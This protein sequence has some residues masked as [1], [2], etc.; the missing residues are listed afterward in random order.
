MQYFNYVIK[1]LCFLAIFNTSIVYTEDSV[2]P[3]EA[4]IVFA[5]SNYFE[6][7]EV[8][9][10]S[11]HEFSS[12]PIIAVGVNDDIPFSSEKYPRLIKKR[13]DQDL[14]KLSIFYQKP[15]VI[16]ES[17]LTYGIYIE[18]DDIL[19]KGCDDLFGYAYEVKNYPI[20]PTH[21]GDP[22]DQQAMMTVLGVQSKSM[23]YVHGH[24]IFSYRCM[25]F[26]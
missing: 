1:I 10:A 14:K 21:P 23:H 7:L 2:K 15:K 20:C 8:T 6:L 26:I 12:R 19:I 5:T 22:N 25:P 16:L 24:V 9:I 13:V 17:G 11:E 18:A 3:E 4:W